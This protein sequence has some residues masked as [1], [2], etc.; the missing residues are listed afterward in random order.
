MCFPIVSASMNLLLYHIQLFKRVCL[1][2]KMNAIYTS[3]ETRV[4]EN[5]TTGFVIFIMC[6]NHET[7]CS[8]EAP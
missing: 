6:G 2:S 3:L 7:T 1:T 4:K 8:M 5:F